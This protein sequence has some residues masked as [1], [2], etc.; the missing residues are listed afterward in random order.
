MFAAKVNPSGMGGGSRN[1]RRM[2][3]GL[4]A[5]RPGITMDSIEEGGDGGGKKGCCTKASF[6][7]RH[8]YSMGAIG[9]VVAYFLGKITFA[10]KQLLQPHVFPA[11]YPTLNHCLCNFVSLY[12]ISFFRLLSGGTIYPLQKF[13]SSLARDILNRGQTCSVFCVPKVPKKE[14]RIVNMEVRV[15]VCVCVCARGRGRGEGES[16]A[17]HSFP[18]LLAFV[19]NYARCF[20]KRMPT[21]LHCI[22]VTP[23][24]T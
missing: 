7:K 19:D 13:N 16:L 14:T 15:C 11:S 4:S 22:F 3:F 2:S 24:L 5:A 17:L 10:M 8:V 12:A 18:C 6:W 21:L 23:T 20:C 1:R 9:L